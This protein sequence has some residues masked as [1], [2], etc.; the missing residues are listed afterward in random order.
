MTRVRSALAGESTIRSSLRRADQGG[1]HHQ[2]LEIHTPALIPGSIAGDQSQTRRPADRE[3][4]RW[5]RFGEAVAAGGADLE[6]QLP[7][8]V[9]NHDPIAY[10]Q[11]AQVPEDALP[12]GPIQVA[13]KDGISGAA[14]PRPQPVPADLQR[15]AR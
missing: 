13:V 11:L 5:R 4:A 10:R 12:T 8:S 14:G 1:L 3:K 6:C 2:P 15:R 7:G 9:V